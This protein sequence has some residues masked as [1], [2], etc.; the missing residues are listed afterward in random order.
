MNNKTG[1]SA[2]LLD[3]PSQETLKQF[4]SLIKDRYPFT[5][6][7]EIIKCD[8]MFIRFSKIETL[9]KEPK[10]GTPVRLKCREFG[11][12]EKAVA[13]HVNTI[14]R[15]VDNKPIVFE[16]P[17]NEIY[18]ITLAHKGPNDAVESNHIEYW[19]STAD[20]TLSELVLS[21]TI[22]DYNYEL[23]GWNCLSSDSSSEVSPYRERS[24]Y[25]LF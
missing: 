13:V 8:H 17:H 9:R 11:F 1:Y 19:K 4:L 7:F 5:K 15:R 10:I 6:Q 16:E 25:G 2:V 24:T 18:H 23:M 20:I 14:E 21:G 3:N 22:C 12:N